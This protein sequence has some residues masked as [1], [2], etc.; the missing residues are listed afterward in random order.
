M[1][2]RDLVVRVFVAAPDDVLGEVAA[3]AELIEELN[4]AH[5]LYSGIRFELINWRAD[6]VPGLG[7]DPQAVINDQIGN[8]YDIFVGILWAKFGTPTP[9]AGSGAEDCSRRVSPRNTNVLSCC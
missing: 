6:V 4:H 9:R 2:R 1:P 8:D 3:L 5:S 7:T